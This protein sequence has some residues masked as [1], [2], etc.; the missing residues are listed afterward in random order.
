VRELFGLEGSLAVDDDRVVGI[1]EDHA[2]IYDLRTLEP[3]SALA[4]AGG[5]GNRVGASEDG[6][7]LLNVGYNNTLTLYDL[8]ANTAL[9]SPLAGTADATRVP[10]GFLTA[11]GERLLEA[12][13]DGIRVWDLRTRDLALHA[14]ALA[15]RELTAD[16]WATYLSGQ[17]QVAT[18]AA[19][20]Q[21]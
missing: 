2:R 17:E 21:E 14:C 12:L 6:R 20:E 13:P 8:T 16:E 5:G 18:C 10:G 4:R 9:G 3:L 19:L 11:D 15:G 7:T 1:G